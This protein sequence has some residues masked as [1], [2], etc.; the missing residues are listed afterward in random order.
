[1]E[2]RQ[3]RANDF[4]LIL[5]NLLGHRS[6]D[7]VDQIHILY[8]AKAPCFFIESKTIVRST[9]S[10]LHDRNWSATNEVGD[11]HLVIDHN[12]F[13]ASIHKSPSNVSH[14]E[15]EWGVFLIAEENP[16][17]GSILIEVENTHAK[18]RSVGIFWIEIQG[19]H[20]FII[21]LMICSIPAHQEIISRLGFA[22]FLLPCHPALPQNINAIP[23]GD[24]RL[25]LGGV[26]RNGISV[27]FERIIQGSQPILIV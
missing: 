9:R 2:L 21:H 10:R 6:C 27:V 20:D 16:H 22:L 14:I 1:M 17:A 18:H 13:F 3:S 8:P 19:F 23:T 7:R 15:R 25:R 11:S 26:G 5:R 24:H 12:F 4:F